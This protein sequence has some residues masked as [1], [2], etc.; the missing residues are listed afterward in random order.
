MTIVQLIM[1]QGQP[2]ASSDSSSDS[3][4]TAVL[5]LKD[6]VRTQQLL[7]YS[8]NCSFHSSSLPV[9]KMHSLELRPVDYSGRE[10]GPHMQA[11]ALKP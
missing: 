9:L 2:I 1:L 11:P 7:L 6:S 5:H 8:S 10:E 3:A 4:V